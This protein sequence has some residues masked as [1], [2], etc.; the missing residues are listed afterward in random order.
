MTSHGKVREDTADLAA[1]HA[2]IGIGIVSAIRS[3]RYRAAFG[4]ITIPQELLPSDM[5]PALY[6]E[7][8]SS[9]ANDSETI[10]LVN[11]YD[12]SLR[13]AVQTLSVMATGHL[14]AA[15]EMQF[16]VPKHARPCFLPVIPSIHYLSKLERAKYDVWD[17]MLLDPSRFAVLLRM[18]RT[19]L[20]G[21]F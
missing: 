15:R 5:Y 1:F 9:G 12:K 17:P 2:G 10:K 6:L 20:T 4:E 8:R 21:V 7:Q 14:N 13:D 16:K 19:W 11:E 3:F 18:V